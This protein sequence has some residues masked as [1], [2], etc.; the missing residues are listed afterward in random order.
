MEGQTIVLL[1]AVV[2]LALATWQL[3]KHNKH[4]RKQHKPKTH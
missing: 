1:V 4:N 3:Y 2:V